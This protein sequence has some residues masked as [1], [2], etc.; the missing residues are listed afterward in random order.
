MVPLTE[1]FENIFLLPIRSSLDFFNI[2]TMI[3]R[4]HINMIA[5]WNFISFLNPFP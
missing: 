4:N 5:T 1:L 3:Y 2:I